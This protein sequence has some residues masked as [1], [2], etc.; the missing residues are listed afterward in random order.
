M[1]PSA[2]R[3]FL[4]FYFFF[5]HHW[6]EVLKNKMRKNLS[7]SIVHASAL[8]GISST[9]SSRACKWNLK[10][11]DIHLCSRRKKKIKNKKSKMGGRKKNSPNSALFSPWS[12]RISLLFFFILFFLPEFLRR[13]F[14]TWEGGGYF[15]QWS[16]PSYSSLPSV[17]PRGRRRGEK[18]MIKR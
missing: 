16:I 13:T 6:P 9:Q 17:L 5:L 8:P 2:C 14:V 7:D 15:D 10:F 18:K 12:R 11:L 4:Y 3:K 1:V